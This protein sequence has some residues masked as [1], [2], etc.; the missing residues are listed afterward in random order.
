M[1]HENNNWKGTFARDMADPGSRLG[2]TVSFNS[3]AT[4]QLVTQRDPKA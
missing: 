2:D 4:E 3:L 1:L